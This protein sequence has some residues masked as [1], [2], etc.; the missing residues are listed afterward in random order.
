MSSAPALRQTVFAPTATALASVAP[1]QD[2]NAAALFTGLVGR[3]LTAETA[4]NT[5]ASQDSAKEPT[6]APAEPAIL[7]DAAPADPQV[8]GVVQA[9]MLPQLATTRT[10]ADPNVAAVPFETTNASNFTPVGANLAAMVQAGLVPKM[11]SEMADTELSVESLED[12]VAPA[13]AQLSGMIQPRAALPN[14]EPVP[15]QQI[16][17]LSAEKRMVSDLPAQLPTLDTKPEGRSDDAP[18]PTAEIDSVKPEPAA[19]KLDIA[20]AV[21]PVAAETPR[22]AFSLQQVAVETTATPYTPPPAIA[23]QASALSHAAIEQL[24][25]LSLA[26]QKRLSDGTTKFQ[27]ELKPADLGRVDVALTI[28]SEGRV[29]A[30]LQFDTPITATTFAARESELRQH[31]T[32]AGLKLDGDALT[33]SSRPADSTPSQSPASQ[34][35]AFSDQQ[36][37]QQARQNARP[38]AQQT[39]RAAKQSDQATIEA[40]LD[41]ALAQLRHRP[42]IGRLALD[43]TV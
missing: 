24:S 19:L 5:T 35:T 28:T 23:A 33:F 12:D 21:K 10:S 14:P 7:P 13:E 43:L 31:L 17:D 39:N 27:L 36:A 16:A 37:G 18:V 1:V 42:G 15:A 32:A 6:K 11:A 25:Q 26:I 34:N 30:H 9:E 40:D 2:A 20:E 41:A 22:P 3:F 29:S 8:A 4:S 38:H